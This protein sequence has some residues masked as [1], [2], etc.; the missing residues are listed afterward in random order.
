MTIEQLKSDPWITG[1]TVN[2]S[3]F[4][5]LKFSWTAQNVSLPT[6]RNFQE[7]GAEAMTGIRAQ[8]DEDLAF[9]RGRQSFELDPIGL[10]TN[11]IFARRTQAVPEE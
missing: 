9:L 8:F 6:P 10:E 3:F 11:P 1:T 4:T 7:G 5:F 2:V